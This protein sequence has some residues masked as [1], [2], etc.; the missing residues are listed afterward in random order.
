MGRNI[1]NV[2]L[3][4]MYIYIHVYGGLSLFCESNHEIVLWPDRTAFQ[5]AL[6]YWPE[7]WDG[8]ARH[9]QSLSD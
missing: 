6:K 3:A 5:L 4:A 8:L 2:Y 1:Y 7:K 9:S